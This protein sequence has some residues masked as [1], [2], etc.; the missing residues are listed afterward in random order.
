MN[1]LKGNISNIIEIMDILMKRDEPGSV[2]DPTDAPAMARLVKMGYNLD[3]IDTA[4]KWL[5]LILSNTVSLSE[6]AGSAGKRP[7]ALRQLH[8]TES[9]RLSP[10][11][12]R[13]LLN[14][15][16]EGRISP[17]QFE[18]TIEYLWSNDLRRVSTSRLEFILYMN[19]PHPDMADSMYTGKNPPA[20]VVH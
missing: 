9:V 6:L 13:Y 4:M 5:T 15:M 1:D 16:D 19:D 2:I 10:D 11:A 17:L 18:R 8:A 3:D 20:G 14:L 7:K 12:Q